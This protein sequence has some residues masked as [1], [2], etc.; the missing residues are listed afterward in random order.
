MS[1]WTSSR[2]LEALDSDGG[3]GLACILPARQ[4]SQMGSG[5]VLDKMV[6]PVTSLSLISLLIQLKV[7]QNVAQTQTQ[8]QTQM[9]DD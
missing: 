2:G 6:M 9:G 1:I 5:V 7:M 8:T 3:N 4:G